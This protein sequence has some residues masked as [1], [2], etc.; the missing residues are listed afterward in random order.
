MSIKSVLND[1]L[2]TQFKQLKYYLNCEKCCHELHKMCNNCE[3]FMGIKQHDYT[4]CKDK[5]CFK[6]YLAYSLLENYIGYELYD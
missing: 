1:R 4:E 6:F 5:E 3:M 2:N